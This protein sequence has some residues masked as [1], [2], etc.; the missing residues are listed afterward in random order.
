MTKYFII[1][2]KMCISL[3]YQIFQRAIT[4]LKRECKNTNFQ[5]PY[6]IFSQKNIEKIYYEKPTTLK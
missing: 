6:L 4:L 1:L 2:F 3:A 5:H